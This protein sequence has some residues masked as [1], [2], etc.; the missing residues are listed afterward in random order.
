MKVLSRSKMA[1]T[2]ARLLHKY[3][4]YISFHVPEGLDPKEYMDKKQRLL[5]APYMDLTQHDM[6]Q[7]WCDEQALIVCRS[8]REM[9]QL[10]WMT[11]GDDG[12]TRYKS[13]SQRRWL[14]RLG[15]KGNIYKGPL[16]VYA[17]TINRNGKIENTNT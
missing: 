7:A 13:I 3:C 11:V 9:E 14:K 15:I 10:F 16:R 1:E 2:I 12:P 5:P 6:C 4:L 17:M 8:R